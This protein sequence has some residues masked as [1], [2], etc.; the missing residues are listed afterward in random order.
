MKV[1]TKAILASTIALTSLCVFLE[2]SSQDRELP[3]RAR[4]DFGSNSGD[5]IA[6]K[7]GFGQNAYLG[8][9]GVWPLIDCEHFGV[10]AVIAGERGSSIRLSSWEQVPDNVQMYSPSV[11]ASVLPGEYLQDYF[12][13]TSFVIVDV[14]SRSSSQMV[15][16][17]NPR[18]SGGAIDYSNT[19][20]E[21]WEITPADG[22][23]YSFRDSSTVPIGQP[24]IEQDLLVDIGSGPYLMPEHRDRQALNRRVLLSCNYSVTAM[25]LDPDGRYLLLAQPGVGILQVD[26]TV[27]ASLSTTTVLPSSTFPFL[28]DIHEMS[29]HQSVS[30]DKTLIAL[31]G[32]SVRTYCVDSD[33]NAV[34]ESVNSFTFEDAQ[35]FGLTDPTAWISDFVHYDLGTFL[36]L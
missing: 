19:V 25:C 21:I 7:E 33:N 6:G 10:T 30:G 8:D 32:D 18:L 23:P 9:L 17:G 34:F 35:T 4:V 1:I 20:V 36:G 12:Y 15:V 14:A 3:Q 5:Q 29:F 16:C 26:L 13:T 28:G 31:S 24:A 2:K 27:P 22:Q 11:A